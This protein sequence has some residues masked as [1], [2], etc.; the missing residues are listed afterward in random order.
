VPT[1]DILKAVKSAVS[2][3]EAQASNLAKQNE[4]V[5]GLAASNSML[6]SQVAEL[7]AELLAKTKETAAQLDEMAAKVAAAEADCHIAQQLLAEQALKKDWRPTLEALVRTV[8]ANLSSTDF[9]ALATGIS[10]ARGAVA[11]AETRLELNEP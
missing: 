5:I 7:E 3:L 1:D 4:R 6:R 11:D 10:H 9:L 2:A 8:K